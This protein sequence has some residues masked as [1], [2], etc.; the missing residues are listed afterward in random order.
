M[1]HVLS[2]AYALERVQAYGQWLYEKSGGWAFDQTAP[3]ANVAAFLN[4][5]HLQLIHRYPNEELHL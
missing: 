3:M 4:R 2:L 1:N 5:A